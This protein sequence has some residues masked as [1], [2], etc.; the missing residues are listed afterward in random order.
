MT[1][2][3]QAIKPPKHLETATKQWWIRV[4]NTWKLKEHQV[5]ILTL[6][7]ESWDRCAQ[8]R[9]AIEENGLTYD[10]RFGQPKA[11]PEVG[12][13]RDSRLAFARLI[14]DLDLDIEEPQEKPE[15]VRK[16][17]RGA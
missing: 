4:R 15:A 16:R 3:K 1:T 17:T 14:R 6:A 5:R 11:R 12:V 7:A 9:V 8:A 2:E 13:E 10:D